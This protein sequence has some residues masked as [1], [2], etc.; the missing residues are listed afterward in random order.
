M[1]A[2]LILN[3]DGT[4]SSND[5]ATD[6]YLKG[7]KAGQVL[8][9]EIKQIRNY[10]FLQKL[11]TLFN[12]VHDALPPLDE[13]EFMGKMIQPENTMENTR[14]YLTVKAGYY[15]VNGYPDGSVRVE[16]KSLSFASMEQEEFD[17]L[18]SDVINASLK[19]LPATWNEELLNDTANQILN[20]G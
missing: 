18:Y 5:E 6:K 14:K 4:L 2:T 19:V 9:C 1:K 15:T 7:R 8:S 17:K 12:L 20:Y 3:P 16:A 13:I 11:M 10:K